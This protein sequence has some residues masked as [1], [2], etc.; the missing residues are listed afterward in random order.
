MKQLRFGLS[1]LTLTFLLLLLGPKSGQAQRGGTPLRYVMSSGNALVFGRP[2]RLC[3]GDVH[4]MGWSPDGMWAA[5]LHVAAPLEIPGVTQ[6][7]PAVVS[8][9]VWRNDIQRAHLL[10]SAKAGHF[11]MERPLQWLPGS[12]QFLLRYSSI[13]ANGTTINLLLVDA[14]QE[15]I[16]EIALQINEEEDICPTR[17]LVI[18]KNIE[19]DGK[20]YRAAFRILNSNGVFTAT[21]DFPAN[22]F[23]TETRWSEN[24]AIY[25]VKT[26]SGKAGEKKSFWR[27]L[28]TR[29]GEWTEM[30]TPPNA[31]SADTRPLLMPPKNLRILTSASTVERDGAKRTIHQAWLASEARVGLTRALIAAECAASDSL[32]EE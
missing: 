17:P 2:E 15:R 22:Q 20:N 13:D 21:G 1:V 27:S 29:T 14:A 19:S 6:T 26:A 9:S 4:D 8:L 11:V 5:A 31:N 28:N 12:A 23:V 24:G 18:F 10:W 25:Q 7:E 3:G 16:H 32:A 30:A